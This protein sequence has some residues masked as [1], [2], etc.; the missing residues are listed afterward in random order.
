MVHCAGEAILG[1]E[2]LRSVWKSLWVSFEP[3]EFSLLQGLLRETPPGG[4]V[5][6]RRHWDSREELISRMEG[7]LRFVS[8]P[9]QT[10]LDEEGG[11]V[12][13]LPPDL[14]AFP[15]P[16]AWGRGDPRELER[17]A[18]ELAFLLRSLGFSLNLAP[19]VDSSPDEP[20][21]LLRSRLFSPDPQKALPYIRAFI[22]GMRAGGIATCLKH[23]PNHGLVQED[24]HE[25]LPRLDLPYDKVRESSFLPFRKGIEE[26][27]EF[28]MMAHILWTP[29]DPSFPMSI[30]SKA[31]DIVRKELNFQGM[32][33]TDD[34]E[35]GALKTYEREDLLIRAIASGVNGVLYCQRL[36]RVLPLVDL[37]VHEVERSPA[38]KRRIRE[39]AERWRQLRRPSPPEGRTIPLS[40]WSDSRV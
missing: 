2:L 12:R 37:L 26:G 33:L 13:R 4:I 30:S 40:G 38:L 35:M 28:L 27:A 20:S 17:S 15:S 22:R 23:F 10:A 34:L 1:S 5:F 36:E 29:L 9:P 21:P 7:I 24:S 6:F 3:D 18:G 19:V 14:P 25:V 39:N 16:E 8:E 32:I 31:V 11:R